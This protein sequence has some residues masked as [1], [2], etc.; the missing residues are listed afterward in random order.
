M[1][2]TV[3]EVMQRTDKN[4]AYFYKSEDGKYYGAPQ[5]IPKKEI[6][7]W[8]AAVRYPIAKPK[9]LKEYFDLARASLHTI[10]DYMVVVYGEQE[11]D[12]TQAAIENWTSPFVQINSEIARRLQLEEGAYICRQRTKFDGDMDVSYQGDVKYIKYDPLKGLFDK[13]LV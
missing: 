13:F 7:N 5:P 3:E 4:M 8:I 2:I 6:K 11:M 10:E 9:N 1:G 12:I